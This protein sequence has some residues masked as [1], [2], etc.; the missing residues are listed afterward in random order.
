MTVG[1]DR[2]NGLKT[3]RGYH[4]GKDAI[5]A[6]VHIT[7]ID[8]DALLRVVP[9]KVGIL[10]K[11]V[12]NHSFNLHNISVLLLFNLAFTQS[13]PLALYAARRCAP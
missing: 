11:W 7:S 9:H 2:H 10:S 5:L 3:S 4:L 8:N 12:K 13:P 6:L 1:V